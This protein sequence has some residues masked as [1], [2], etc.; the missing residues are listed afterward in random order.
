[1][2]ILFVKFSEMRDVM[3]VLLPIGQVSVHKKSAYGSGT[4][5][6]IFIVLEPIRYVCA[7]I[8]IIK[9]ACGIRTVYV[10]IT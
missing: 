5:S 7:I 4:V 3:F 1:M 10:S 6:L 8:T 2:R 9:I